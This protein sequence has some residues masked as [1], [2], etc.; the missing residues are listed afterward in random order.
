MS[1]S[2]SGLEPSTVEQI[3][4]LKSSESLTIQQG[5]EIKG[6]GS[7]TLAL[8]LFQETTSKGNNILPNCMTS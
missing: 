7:L 6:R 8:S 4:S 3:R 2:T 5:I 1:Q